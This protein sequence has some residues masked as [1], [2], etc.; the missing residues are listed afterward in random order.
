MGGKKIAIIDDKTAYG[1]GLAD[2]AEKAIKAAGGA[3]SRFVK[4]WLTKKNKISKAF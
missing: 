3:M 1:V 4:L 2:E